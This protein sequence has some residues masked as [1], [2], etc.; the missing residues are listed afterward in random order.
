VPAGWNDFADPGVGSSF[1]NHGHLGVTYG[2]AVSLGGHYLLAWAQDDRAT[3]ASAPDGD[4]QIIGA[5][6]RLNMGRFGHLY[7][8]YSNVKATSARVVGRIVEVL[9][10][11]GGPGLIDNYLGQNSGGTGGLDILGW[12]YDLSI[13]RLISYP[14]PFSG[15]GPDIYFSLFGI[16]AGIESN[17]PVFDG[18]SR[19]KFGG[20]GSY[21]LLPWLALSFRYDNVRPGV[22]PALGGLGGVQQVLPG[23]SEDDFAFQVFAPR[24]ILRSDWQARDQVVIQWAHWENNELTTVRAGY[25]AVEDLSVAPDKDVISISANMWW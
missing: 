22:A 5:D 7:G 23:A 16:Y 18:T 19:I 1:V 21:S 2:N 8:A 25:P 13:G 10:T 3:G 14:V 9:N 20:E 15:D 24:I 12:Q 4:I 6:L 17:D 11:R